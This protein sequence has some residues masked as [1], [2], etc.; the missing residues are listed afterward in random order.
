MAVCVY[1]VRQSHLFS[2]NVFLQAAYHYAFLV[3]S[4]WTSYRSLNTCLIERRLLNTAHPARKS[5]C[6]RLD[7]SIRRGSLAL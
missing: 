6:I 7:C 2:I 4:A 1:S 3:I 5:R